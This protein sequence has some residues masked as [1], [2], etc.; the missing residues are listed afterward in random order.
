MHTASRKVLAA[1]TPDTP[2]V[3]DAAGMDNDADA[4]PSAAPAADALRAAPRKLFCCTHPILL[5]HRVAPEIS[6]R[7]K[8]FACLLADDP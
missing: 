3:L 4:E 8:C 7:V 6:D 2:G 1:R 5:P